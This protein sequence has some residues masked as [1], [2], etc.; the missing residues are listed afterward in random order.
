MKICKKCECI[1]P[2]YHNNCP[3]CGSDENKE[4]KHSAGKATTNNSYSDIN[5]TNDKSIEVIDYKY[6]DLKDIIQDS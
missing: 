3:S 4:W 6:D 5:K 2:D 1:F